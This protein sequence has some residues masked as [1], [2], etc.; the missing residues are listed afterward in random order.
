M[1]SVNELNITNFQ[2][3]GLNTSIPRYTFLLEMKYT[4]DDGVLRTYGPTT[5]TWPN[6]LTGIPLDV[7]QK[8]ITGIIDAKAR[9]SVGAASWDDYR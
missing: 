8:M 2:A 4:L 3:T 7:Q 9:V 1:A 5:H 6:D